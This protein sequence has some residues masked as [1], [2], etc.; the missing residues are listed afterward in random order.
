MAFKHEDYC[1]QL[2]NGGIEEDILTRRLFDV[3]MR[4]FQSSQEYNAIVLHIC[5]YM[6]WCA[7]TE[8]EGYK[9]PHG[10][11][12]ANAGIP[13]NII[14][15][16]DG[17]VMINPKIFWTSQDVRKVE[18]NC[19]SL[20]L[21]EPITIER[22]SHIRCSF[23]DEDGMEHEIDGYLPTVQHETDH[24]NGILITDRLVT[25]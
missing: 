10:Y 24:N 17:R 11:S 7:T 22:Y 18:S 21:E 2:K 15:L 23:F 20:L 13:F 3:N 1:T 6:R 5:S 9:K 16:A 25:D 8:K 19:G 14:A 12:G 4:L